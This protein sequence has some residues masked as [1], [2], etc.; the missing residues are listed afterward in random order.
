MQVLFILSF[1][2]S[3]AA[4]SIGFLD[5][6]RKTFNESENNIIITLT[7]NV[8]TA[9]D[10]QVNLV[11]P[12]GKVCTV[13]NSSMTQQFILSSILQ[14]SGSSLSAQNPIVTLAAGLPGSTPVTLRIQQDSIGGEPDESIVLAL[15]LVS[16]MNFSHLIDLNQ[17]E[18]IIKDDDIGKSDIHDH[19]E[20]MVTVYLIGKNLYYRKFL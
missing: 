19:I 5:S 2:L 18:I 6:Q 4:V 17:L 15:E 20:D 3:L 9:Q 1:F 8:A 12:E 11:I 13:Y 16:P 14:L 10:I 7:K